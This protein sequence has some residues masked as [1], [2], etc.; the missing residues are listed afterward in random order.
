[1][2]GN[3][4]SI[5]VPAYNVEAYIEKTVKSIC[6]QTYRNLEIILVNDGSQD[7]TS[8]VLDCLEKQDERIRVIH[9]ENGGV[10]SARLRGVEESTG[11]WIGFVDGDDYVEPNMYELLL[12]NAL[13]YQADISHCGYQ[14][15]FP[16]RVD[17][18]YGTGKRIEQNH[19]D[20]LRDLLE[21][22]FVEPGLWN[23]LF[24]K[25]LLV[26]MINRNLMDLSIKIN[27]DLLMNFYLFGFAKKSVYVDEC[28]Y[29]YVLRKGSAATSE[30]NE[31]KLQ[32]PLRVLK[33]IEAEITN[34][35]DLKKI[36][37]ERILGQLISIS[38]MNAKQQREM[39]IPYRKAAR[40]ELRK[41]FFKILRSDFRF[42]KKFMVFFV[43][44]CPDLYTLV[45]TIY[46]KITGLN[47]KYD[48]V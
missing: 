46:A 19:K 36:I 17:D 1:M 28:L 39:I 11:E 6:E 20:G 40:R 18:Y 5:V 48:V 4:I 42:K 9:K 23:K 13:K 33:T 24:R 8:N 10:T 43:V 30:I 21:G 38:T 3:K 15:V 37:R 2:K 44:V 26:Q 25:E 31:Y 47:K 35:M 32:D 7:N 34:D 29:L 22:K 14:M 27:E 41:D 16:S 12:E 45:H